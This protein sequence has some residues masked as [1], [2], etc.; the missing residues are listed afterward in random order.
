MDDAAV[1]GSGSSGGSSGGRVGDVGVERAASKPDSKRARERE[2]G[3]RGFP[4]GRIAWEV[5]RIRLNRVYCAWEID[6][7]LFK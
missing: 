6:G 4:L 3:G 2:R 5:Y 1:R 7:S